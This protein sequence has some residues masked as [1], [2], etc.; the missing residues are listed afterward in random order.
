MVIIK[1]LGSRFHAFEV[2]IGRVIAIRP[3]ATRG[4]A[5]KRQKQ[6]ILQT[7][8]VYC[9][10]VRLSVYERALLV[11]AWYAVRWGGARVLAL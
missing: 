8:W 2:P 5:V 11:R 6:A 1:I 4:E 3:V 7:I 10:R 9:P